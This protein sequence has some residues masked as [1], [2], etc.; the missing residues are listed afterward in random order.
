MTGSG[1]IVFSIF[2]P[3]TWR[4]ILSGIESKPDRLPQKW[5]RPKGCFKHLVVR[6]YN[7]I[8]PLTDR[9]DYLNSMGNN[10]GHVMT[11]ERLFGI[12]ITERCKVLRVIA[13]ELSRIAS[14]LVWVGTT[15][16]DI[17]ATIPSR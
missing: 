11:A 16:I 6:Q 7:Q 9:E 14:H 3:P 13:C 12:E 2:R 8:L 5:D 10:V 4:R 17:G 15:C 1:S